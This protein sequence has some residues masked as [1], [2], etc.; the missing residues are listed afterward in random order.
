M[1]NQ[2]AVISSHYANRATGRPISPLAGLLTHSGPRRARTPSTQ[3]ISPHSRRS[4]PRRRA[5]PPGLRSLLGRGPSAASWHESVKGISRSNR[6]ASA[7]AAPLWDAPGNR[8]APG[9]RKRPAGG[10]QEGWALATIYPSP[11]PGLITRTPGSSRCSSCTEGTAMGDPRAPL[12][13]RRPPGTSEDTPQ[14]GSGPSPGAC[15]YH[16]T[17]RSAWP[18]S[19]WPRSAWPRWVARR[20]QAT[21]SPTVN[22]HGELLPMNYGPPHSQSLRECQRTTPDLT[23]GCLQL[24]GRNHGCRVSGRVGRVPGRAEPAA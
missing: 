23:Q 22:P 9:N 16:Q 2:T 8:N 3:Q 4:S 21:Q 5:M 1:D 7:E 17:S 12:P 11:A 13:K 6:R 18:R 10:S 20:N 19:A 14:A 15:R 24:P